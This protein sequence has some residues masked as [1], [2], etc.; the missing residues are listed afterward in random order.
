MST[1]NRRAIAVVLA[2]IVVAASTVILLLPRSASSFHLEAEYSGD[3]ID[4]IYLWLTG[5][6]DCALNVSFVDDPDLMYEIDVELYESQP[7]S[8]AFDLSVNEWLDIRFE[9]ILSIKSLQ[10]TLGSGV[11]YK[12]VV[13]SGSNMNAT[14]IYENN[15]IGSEASLEYAATGSFVNLQFSEDMVFSDE[16]MEIDVG[17]GGVNRPDNIYLT[18][19]LANG[20]NGFGQFSKPLSVHANTGWT[21]QAE[22]GDFISYGTEN[23]SYQ[24]RVELTLW[25][26]YSV[27]AWL[28]D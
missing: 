27:H 26:E 1:M 2:L 17:T 4:P 14:L 23:H 28:S 8:S 9:A 7:A 24:P 6:Q 21:W 19:D 22:V 11:S 10:V 13:L 15:V 18:L 20:V 3:G 12:I 5:L 25:A 16:G